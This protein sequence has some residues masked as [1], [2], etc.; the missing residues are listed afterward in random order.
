M[1]SPNSQF[2]HMSRAL[3]REVIKRFRGLLPFIPRQCRIFRQLNR[4]KTILYLDFTAYPQYLKM[5][6]QKWSDL[7]IWLALS[8]NQLGLAHSVVWKDG[9]RIVGRM[10]LDSP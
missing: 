5:N 3:E 6:E 4:H 8:C 10:T 7:T 1:S 9:E 2:D